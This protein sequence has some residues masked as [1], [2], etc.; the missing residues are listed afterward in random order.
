MPGNPSPCSETTVV[1]EECIHCRER[2]AVL[3]RIATAHEAR[4]LRHE[5]ELDEIKHR[6]ERA[7]EQDKQMLVLLERI[8]TLV[9]PS[10]KTT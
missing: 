6:N 9:T 3:E 8:L 10:A 2:L 7:D 5:D 4:L 1:P